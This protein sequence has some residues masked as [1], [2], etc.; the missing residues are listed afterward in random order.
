MLADLAWASLETP[1]GLLRLYGSPQ[2]LHALA[3]P[4]MDY[5]KS[6]R[7]LVIR[8]KRNGAYR[9]TFREDREQLQAALEQLAEYFAGA[10]AAFDLP[11]APLGTP[12]QQ[13]VWR[14]IAKIP[15]GR[16]CSYQDLALALGTP[17]AVRVV[18]R[19]VAT[20]PLPIVIPCHRVIGRDG[21]LI[22]YAGGLALKAWLLEHEQRTTQV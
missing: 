20:N 8:W 4:G 1:V 6:E 21:R 9:V 3:L 10:R 11:L 19:A 13:R 15:Y 18:A 2:G 7:Q 16:T 22:G 12:F 17:R 14:E 5:E